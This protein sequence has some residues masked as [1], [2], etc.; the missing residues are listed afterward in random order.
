MP[1]LQKKGSSPDI[2]Q[3]KS[4]KYVKDVSYVGH[5]RFVQNVTNIPV[6]APDVPVGVRLHQFWE[7]W[8]ALGASAK[9]K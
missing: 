1:L 9:V 5:L 8:A 6:F 3:Q 4:S 7:T 2:A